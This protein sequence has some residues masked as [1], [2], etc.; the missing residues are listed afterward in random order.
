MRLR[1]STVVIV[2]SAVAA[3]GL[4]IAAVSVLIDRFID[5]DVRDEVSLTLGA[6]RKSLDRC[7]AH[8][9]PNPAA[10]RDFCPNWPQILDGY[11]LCFRRCD[12]TILSSGSASAHVGDHGADVFE[13]IERIRT[14]P[15]NSYFTTVVL[16][17]TCFCGV[18]DYRENRFVAVMPLTDLVP[19]YRR[20]LLSVGLVFLTLVVVFALAALKFAALL[21]RLHGYIEGEKRRQSEDLAAAHLVQMSALPPPPPHFASFSVQARMDPAKVVGGDFYDYQPL[22]NGHFYFLVADVSGKGISAAMFMMRAKSVIKQCLAETGD[23]SKGMT[24]ANAILATHNE[25]LLFVTAWVGV[26]NPR[27]G[28]VT[29]VNAGHNP[30]VVR[31]ANEGHS[32]MEWV[33]C[34]PS[35]VMAL[36]PDVQYPVHELTLTPG[37][38]LFL[39][40]DGVTEAQD[41]RGRFYGEARL[42]HLLASADAD[43]VGRVRADL[44]AFQGG[45]EPADD[46][47]MLAIGYSGTPPG[48]A[49]GFPC[50]R[51]VG[52]VESERF[53]EEELARVECP[54]AIRSKFMLAYDEIGSNVVTYSGAEYFTVKVATETTPQAVTLTVT[55]AGK[56]FN[57]LD[58]DAPDLNLSIEKRVSG[59]FGIFI[60]RQLMDD[61]IYSRDEGHNVLTLRKLLTPSGDK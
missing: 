15:T 26:L 9:A 40:T 6:I 55:D 43:C 10:I 3:F 13:D 12:G 45:T 30:P 39:Y 52:L 23:L 32:A 51:E 38:T 54:T 61:V 56:P 1:K 35:L 36:M 21:E 59:G 53:I 16:G 22:P 47:T 34:P 17:E 41:G 33:R 57:P 49:R 58:K 25:S 2:F 48:A 7:Y 42:E 29:Y 31:H 27:T 4:S 20:S 50:N 19:Y 11:V 28:L 14:S 24:K 46:V 44:D 8:G 5:T 18:M 37:D 60:T